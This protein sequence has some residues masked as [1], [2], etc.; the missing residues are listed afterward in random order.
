MHN[1]V[2]NS[3]ALFSSLRDLPQF[4]PPQQWLPFFQK[5]FEA[6]TLLWKFQ[7]DRRAT[8]EDPVN[9]VGLNRWD[10]GEIVNPAF[11]VIHESRQTRSQSFDARMS[12]TE[13]PDVFGDRCDQGIRFIEFPGGQLRC[14]V[15][16]VALIN[17]TD[18]DG[19][20]S[21]IHP[22]R[23]MTVIHI[24]HAAIRTPQ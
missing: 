2:S 3:N 12:F 18:P 9:G 6:F 7:Q 16:D 21:E 1:L 15:D 20:R 23:Q 14:M 17:H 22:N 24:N 13:L 19:A 11:V 5:A 8:L 10:I 4:G